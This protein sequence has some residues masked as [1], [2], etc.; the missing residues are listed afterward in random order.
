MFHP[1]GPNLFLSITVEWKKQRP[2]KMHLTL[3]SFSSTSSL[4]KKVK[5][6]FM[7]ALIPEG[8]SLV[9]LMDLSKIPIGTP[10]EGYDDKSNLK[11]M[12]DPPVSPENESN[13]FRICN[14]SCF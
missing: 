3:G 1:R 6:L 5:A 4:G 7:L 9:S 11:L 13:I 8:G 14:R 2:N 10:V 12:W